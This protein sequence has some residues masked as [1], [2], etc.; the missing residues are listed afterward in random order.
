[1]EPIL[2]VFSSGGGW[3][4]G[5][6]QE[7]IIINTMLMIKHTAAICFLYIATSLADY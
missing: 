6:V 2:R 5:A 3:G 7:V 1:M 4:V